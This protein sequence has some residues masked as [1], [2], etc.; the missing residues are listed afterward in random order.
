MSN[1]MP[2]EPA[3]AERAGE[4]ADHDRLLAE[5][6]N[7]MRRSRSAGDAFDEAAA[8]YL[9]VNRTDLRCM[10]ILRA[11]QPLTAGELAEASG[12]SPG[13]VT[14]LL[15]RLERAGYVRRVRDG[16][17]RRRVMVELTELATEKG[18][19]VWSQDPTVE[20]VRA[21]R[22]YTDDQLRAV[23]EITRQGR[24]AID[25]HLRRIQELAVQARAQRDQMRA[26]RDEVKAAWRETKAELKGAWKETKG[27]LKSV[28]KEPRGGQTKRDRA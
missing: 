23:L 2:P 16:R 1:E 19:E 13:A 5:I 24:Q 8:G 4:P 12:L 20:R 26:A 27:E 3:G 18:A 22:G 15:D 17:D 28:L 11:H 7:E 10:G 14:A 21:A 25:V 9:G 6:G